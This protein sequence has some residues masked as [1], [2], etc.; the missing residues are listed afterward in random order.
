MKLPMGE[1]K[2]LRSSS[3]IACNNCATITHD[4]LTT[5]AD[6]PIERR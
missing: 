5:S 2:F 6:P 1:L 3:A 4:L